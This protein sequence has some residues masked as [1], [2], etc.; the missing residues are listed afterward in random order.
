MFRLMSRRSG[1]VIHPKIKV[2]LS[3]SVLDEN[4][5]LKNQFYSL[6]LNRESITYLPTTWTLVHSIDEGSP[7]SKYSKNEIKE[8]KGE[9]LILFS[10]HDEHYNQEL[11]QVHSYVFKDIKV[12]C[13]F[14]KAYYYNENGQITLDHDLVDTIEP[15]VQNPNPVTKV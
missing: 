15:Q 4:G 11:H 12:D 3:L 14:K 13:V 1:L 2:S 9:L 5:A 8:L 10:Y 7:L 6:P